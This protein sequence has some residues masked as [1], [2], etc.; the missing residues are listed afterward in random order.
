MLGIAALP[1]FAQNNKIDSLTKLLNTA[2]QD[3]TKAKVL[4]ERAW[5]YIYSNPD[6]A[7][8]LAQKQ[9]EIAER[10]ALSEVE[11]AGASKLMAAALN[12]QGIS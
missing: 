6:T 10:H 2:K 4:D 12:T 7:F 11:G 5:S 3:T 1:V 9:Y 8:T